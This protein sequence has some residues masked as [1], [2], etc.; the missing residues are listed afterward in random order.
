MA[1]ISIRY[2][3]GYGHNGGP[4]EHTVEIDPDDLPEG[5]TEEG[6]LD[7]I[8]REVLND[9]GRNVAPHD[10]VENVDEL[11]AQ[12]AAARRP[13]APAK[14]SGKLDAQERRIVRSTAPKGGA[15]RRR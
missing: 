6:A 8:H 2:A 14:P 1:K 11:A 3:A 4:A 12:L 10:L 9:I 15:R 7:A 13:A 5:L